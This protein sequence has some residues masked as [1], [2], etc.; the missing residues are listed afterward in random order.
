MNQVLGWNECENSQTLSTTTTVPKIHKKKPKI[1]QA[2]RTVF[3]A[4]QRS[5]L[6]RFLVFDEVNFKTP[7]QQSKSLTSEAETGYP[8]RKC[9]NHTFKAPCLVALNM[10]LML[11]LLLLKQSIVSIDCN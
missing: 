4:P 9:C 10:D 6:Y 8:N 11:H 1:R 3:C 7:T 5:L 2:I